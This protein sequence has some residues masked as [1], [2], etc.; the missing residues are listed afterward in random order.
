M[1]CAA[2]Q[3]VVL[4]GGTNDFRSTTPPLEEWTSDV[5]N[6]LDMVSFLLQVSTVASSKF[7]N[8]DTG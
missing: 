7:V 8:E 5:I 6:F 4:A 2:L 1:T 3:V